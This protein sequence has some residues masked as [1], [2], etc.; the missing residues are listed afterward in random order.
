[1]F[2]DE[3]NKN[4]FVFFCF[5][6]AVILGFEL[7]LA[8]QALYHLNHIL[9]PF[10]AL[11]IF[12][13]LFVFLFFHYFSYFAMESHIFA[14]GEPRIPILLPMSPVQPGLHICTTTLSSLSDL[15][16]PADL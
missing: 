11:V 3:V 9:Q 6:F 1:M 2:S 10:C 7:M 16:A 13:C 15:F 14:Q 5:F 4:S 8:K 12:V